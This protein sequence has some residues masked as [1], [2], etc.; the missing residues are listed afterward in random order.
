MMV[1]VVVV[2]LSYISYNIGQQKKKYFLYKSLISYIIELN[3]CI[4]CYQ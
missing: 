2:P 3:L 4:E 1:M